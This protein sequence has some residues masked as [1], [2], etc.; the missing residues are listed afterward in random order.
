MKIVQSASGKST[1][2]KV[3]I[4]GAGSD[5]PAGALITMGVTADTDLGAFIISGAAAADAVG[6]LLSLHDFSVVGDT[7]I[8]DAAVRVMGEV[9]LLHPGDLVAVEYDQTDTMAVASATSTTAVV[10]SDG[11]SDG[12][13]HYVVSGTGIGQLAYVKSHDTDT[14]TYKSALTT[15]LDNTST[16][17]RI[18]R[19]GEILASLNTARTKF[20]PDAALGSA[21]FLTLEVQCAYDGQDWFTLDFVKHHNLQLNG[22]NAKFRAIGC[23]RDLAVSPIA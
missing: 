1:I 4:D 5:I 13:W 16:L 19:P 14:S 6:I 8:E 21:D 9:E 17:I 20:G 15:T 11:T 10:T 3:P 2:V 22:K 18:N 23:F 7:T 12:C